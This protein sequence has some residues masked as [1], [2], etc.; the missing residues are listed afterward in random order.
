MAR[1]AVLDGYPRNITTWNISQVFDKIDAAFTWS[2]NSHTYMFSGD[3][4]IRYGKINNGVSMIITIKMYTFV[5]QS[6]RHTD[7]TVQ[8]KKLSM[9]SNAI[10]FDR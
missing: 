6:I 3:Q 9:L 5:P 2:G 4:Y 7:N 10:F 1:E 8:Q